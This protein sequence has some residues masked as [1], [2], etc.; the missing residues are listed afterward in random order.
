M[1]E[2]KELLY[3]AFN[4]GFKMCVELVE[5]SYKDEDFTEEQGEALIKV[6]TRLRLAHRKWMHEQNNQEYFGR[7]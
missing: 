6:I 4:D 3:N 7:S 5:H 1:R 2:P